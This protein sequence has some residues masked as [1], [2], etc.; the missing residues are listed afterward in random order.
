MSCRVCYLRVENLPNVTASLGRSGATK[1]AKVW[2][3]IQLGKIKQVI[4]LSVRRGV[5]LH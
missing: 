3:K 1:K 5:Q 4:N 2:H